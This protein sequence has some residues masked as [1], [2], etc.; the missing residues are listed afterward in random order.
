MDH[1]DTEQAV[2]MEEYS[3]FHSESLNEDVLLSQPLAEGGREDASSG[4]SWA[5]A[6]ELNACH[7][8]GSGPPL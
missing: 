2:M 5:G 1:A 7:E 6:T 3:A 4:S 8:A